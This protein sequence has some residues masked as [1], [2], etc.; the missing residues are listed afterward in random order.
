MGSY[1]GSPVNLSVLALSVP[2]DDVL[3]QTSENPVQN[4]VVTKGLK[5]KVGFIE[6]P[7]SGKGELPYIV[8]DEDGKKQLQGGDTLPKID[9]LYIPQLVASKEITEEGIIRIEFEDLSPVIYDELTVYIY[10]PPTTENWGY[11]FY[12][13]DESK[14]VYSSYY[15][16]LSV[17]GKYARYDCKFSGKSWT[18]NKMSHKNEGGSGNGYSSRMG[19][20]FTG[21][22]IT[23][24]RLISKWENRAV[25]FPVGTTIEIYGKVIV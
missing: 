13:G 5:E 20:T 6:N 4:K 3:S 15:N 19:S 7:V 11:F 16:D 1:N 12:L 14:V 24:V 2:I 23:R 17:E 18:V 25:A 9:S 10:T 21:S 8:Y 22:Q